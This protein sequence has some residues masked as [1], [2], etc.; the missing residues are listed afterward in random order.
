MRSKIRNRDDIEDRC[1]TYRDARWELH[2]REDDEAYAP[3]KLVQDIDQLE[4]TIV[5]REIRYVA[6]IEVTRRDKHPTIKNPPPSYFEAILER[7]NKDMQGKCAVETAKKLGCE[8]YIVVFDEDMERLWVYNLN[9]KRG[10]EQFNKQ[11]YFQWIKK[12]HEKV[13]NE[14]R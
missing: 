10:F 4:Y 12:K 5:D 7:Y 13:A 3:P 11:E 2:I 14:K 9:Q 8:A 1:A 6:I